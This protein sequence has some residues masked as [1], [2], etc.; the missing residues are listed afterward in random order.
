MELKHLDLKAEVKQLAC[1][2]YIWNNQN[3]CLVKFPAK[4]RFLAAFLSSYR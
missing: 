3:S 2:L 4:L 1:L